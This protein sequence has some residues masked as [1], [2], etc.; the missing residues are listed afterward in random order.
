M[1]G[2]E[3]P[4]AVHGARHTAGLAAFMISLGVNGR[5]KPGEAHEGDQQF[6]ENG[7]TGIGK[8]QTLRK[9]GNAKINK[10]LAMRPGFPKIIENVRISRYFESPEIDFYIPENALGI[11]YPDTWLSKLLH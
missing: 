6:G 10:V 9:D 8:S 7:R 5:T 1:A 4:Y 3:E 2:N 11:D